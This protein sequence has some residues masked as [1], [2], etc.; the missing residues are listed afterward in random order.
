M[1]EVNKIGKGYSSPILANGIIYMT[2]MIDTLDYLSA[3]DMQG[4]IKWQV[5]YGRSWNKSFPDTRSS[6]VVDGNRI[7]V[8]SGTGKLSCI[9]AEDGNSIWSVEVD[10]DFQTEYHMWGNSETPLVTDKLVICTPG[11]KQTSVVAFDKITGKLAWETK[12]VG[13]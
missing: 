11:G 6:P 1:L 5:Q 10:K 12:S 8:Q 13:G 9:N 2:G 7:Y 4:N 3:I